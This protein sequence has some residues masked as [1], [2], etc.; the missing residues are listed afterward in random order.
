MSWDGVLR[1]AF[2]VAVQL[3]S[4]R[5]S[6]GDLKQAGDKHSLEHSRPQEQPSAT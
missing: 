4:L 2:P 1:S 5:C 6:H 3:G